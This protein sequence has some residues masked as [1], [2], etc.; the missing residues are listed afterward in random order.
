[1]HQLVNLSL[2]I[3]DPKALSTLLLDMSA[4]DHTFALR[5][6]FLLH[7]QDDYSLSDIVE[8]LAHDLE[9][10]IVN[11][12]KHQKSSGNLRIPPHLYPMDGA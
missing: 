5:T 12:E 2:H 3:P 9:M 6:M 8:T 11:G 4:K 10:V 1:M 7:A